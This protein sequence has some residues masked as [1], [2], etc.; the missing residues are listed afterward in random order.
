MRNNRVGNK[1]DFYKIKHTTM[2]K[3]NKDILIWIH[4]NLG[5]AIREL[6]DV[7]Y[8][9]TPYTEALIA[10]IACRETGCLI[11]PFVNKGYD[12]ETICNKMIGDHGH[13][14]GFIQ[15]DDRSYPV[16]LRDT[17]LSD[18]KAYL[19]KAILVLEEKRKYIES[20]GFTKDKLG[21]DEWLRAIVAAYNTGQG[22]VVKSLA[23]GLDVDRTTYNGDYSK[24]VM[25]FRYT[26]YEMY[27][28]TE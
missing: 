19:E 8:A 3:T 10:G 28:E 1:R 2:I 15:I 16:F 14:Y 26:Y 18:Y 12:F 24:E 6:T 13:G 20:K 7:K 21:E 23:R 25:Q 9:D 17:P 11:K 4:D 5:E 22:N 27:K